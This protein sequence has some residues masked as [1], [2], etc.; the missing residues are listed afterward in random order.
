ML[1][2]TTSCVCS[3]YYRLRKLGSCSPIAFSPQRFPLACFS[4]LLPRALLFSASRSLPASLP[5]TLALF[6]PLA[7]SF[8]LDA[9]FTFFFDLLALFLYFFPLF[10]FLAFLSCLVLLSTFL[11]SSSSFWSLPFSFP[12]LALLFLLLLLLLLFYSI[13][14]LL[15]I[16]QLFFDTICLFHNGA[17]SVTPPFSQTPKYLFLLFAVLSFPALGGMRHQPPC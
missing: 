17:R 6:A 13:C 7:L 10:A 8:P 15:L 9:P 1:F 2:S 11:L 14:W 5:L 12:F 4:P 16:S 3:T